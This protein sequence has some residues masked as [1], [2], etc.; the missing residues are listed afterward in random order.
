MAP[1][2]SI[3]PGD[4]A[5]DARADVG[6][7]RVI[8]LIGR[9]TSKSGWCNLKQLNIAIELGLTRETVNRKIRDLV[10]W[11]YVEKRSIDATG[12]AIRYRTIM[13]RPASPPL[14]DSGD[15]DDEATGGAVSDG[16]HVGCNTG[17]TCNPPLTS[18]VSAKDHIRCDHRKSQQERSS[19]NDQVKNPKPRSAAGATG[20]EVDS[21]ELVGKAS[22]LIVKLKT[23]G[24][25]EGVVE[26][27]LRPI[28]QS[29]RFSAADKA[30]ELLRL[31]AVAKDLPVEALADA[32]KYVLDSDVQTIK[33]QRI[34]EAITRARSLSAIVV[35]RKGSA[36][37]Q[38]WHD[39]FAVTD[40][41]QAEMLDRF[42]AWQV[43]TRWP[44]RRGEAS[45]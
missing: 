33:P 30:G 1:R 14:L 38:A 6:H 37:W 22:A 41:K 32:A 12:R 11:G 43:P 18:D 7:F 3:I 8:N 20:L 45:T 21:P 27:L 25:D 17:G 23:S 31:V 15:E 42:D 36:E 34:A 40:K 29:R 13:D 35:I 9:H 44:P 39:H 4:F 24:T 10:D 19:L 2:Y 26:H 28:L 16:S 5:A